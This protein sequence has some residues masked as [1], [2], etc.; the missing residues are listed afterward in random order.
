MN[1]YFTVRRRF[2]AG[3][4]D[5]ACSPKQHG[6][7]Y[8]IEATAEAHEAGMLRSSLDAF[9]REVDLRMLS[10]QLPGVNPTPMGIS[11]FFMERTKM[12]VPSLCRV[13]VDI[14]NV[15]ESWYAAEE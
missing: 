13:E 1:S 9:V 14:S 2:E 6:H 3:C 5:L 15:D 10:E 12:A 4:I 7:L 11:R 8:N